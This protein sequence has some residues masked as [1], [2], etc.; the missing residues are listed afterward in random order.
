MGAY[1]REVLQ[2]QVRPFLIAY[3]NDWDTFTDV[4]YILE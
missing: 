1:C 4:P 2:F 3:A